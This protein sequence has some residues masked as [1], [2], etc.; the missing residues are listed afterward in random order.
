MK[1]SYL[2]LLIAGVLPVIAAGIAKAGAKGYD[3]HDPRAWMAMQTGRR[4]RADAAQ[5]NSFEAF[6]FFAAGVLLA[7]QAGAD[8]SRIDALAIVFVLARVMYIAC[9]VSDRASLRS[10]FWAVGYLCVLALYAL[11][12]LA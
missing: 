10:L 8:T 2:C 5:A 1:W 4:A 3:N 12:M 11:A 7:L 9:Y 6:P